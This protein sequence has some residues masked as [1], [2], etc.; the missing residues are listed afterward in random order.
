LA[1]CPDFWLGVRRRI[2]RTIDKRGPFVL[3]L[4]LDVVGNQSSRIIPEFVGYLASGCS[5]CLKSRINPHRR[6]QE[7][8]G[9]S[10][11]PG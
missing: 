3:R 1:G 4:H 11:A 5:D 7:V 2:H 9:E 8:R 6:L 10:P